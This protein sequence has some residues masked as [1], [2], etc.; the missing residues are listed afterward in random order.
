MGY[1]NAQKAKKY[2][3]GKEEL[4]ESYLDDCKINKN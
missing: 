3:K 4:W 2:L 1:D